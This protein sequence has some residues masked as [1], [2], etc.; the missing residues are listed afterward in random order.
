MGGPLNIVALVAR[1]LTI[2][3]ETINWY[4]VHIEN[5]EILNK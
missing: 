3:E 5:S 1:I 4:V 2:M